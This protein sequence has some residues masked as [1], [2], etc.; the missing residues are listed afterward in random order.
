M[1]GEKMP[2]EKAT[3]HSDIFVISKT[4][5]VIRQAPGIGSRRCNEISVNG[6]RDTNGKITP[7]GR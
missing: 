7:D 5:K 6:P 2:I 1:T 3:C 4:I